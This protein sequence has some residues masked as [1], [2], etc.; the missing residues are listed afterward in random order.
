M[1]AWRSFERWAHKRDK[2]GQ[3]AL[4][5]L[6]GAGFNAQAGVRKSWAELLQDVERSA[7]SCVD[8]PSELVG[9]TTLAWE[10]LV[11]ASSVASRKS[12]SVAEKRLLRAMASEL[13]RAYPPDGATRAFAERFLAMRFSD[14]ISFNFDR[15]LHVQAAAWMRAKQGFST[16]KSYAQLGATRLWYPHGCVTHP[17]SIHLGMREYGG[18]I[19]ELERARKQ[20]KSE[21]SALAKKLKGRAAIW[22]AQR[23][24]PKSWLTVAMS[25]PLVFV[26]FGLGREEWPLWWFL[27]Q[28]ARNHARAKIDRPV[29]AF[30]KADEAERL[31]VAAELARIQLLTFDD[32][33]SGWERLLS[34]L[35]SP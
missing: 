35:A 5:P 25:A 29:F 28:R 7:G 11:L 16:T 14:V 22:A 23:K 13:D 6:I 2:H 12:P 19:A 27:N 31:R 32:F 17:A 20:F 21:E 9:N 18:F 4:V 1:D 24:D 33:E 15:A 3:H 10:A 30:M 8:L 34:A 26:G